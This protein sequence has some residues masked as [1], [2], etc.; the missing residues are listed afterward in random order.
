[1]NDQLSKRLDYVLEKYHEILLRTVSI[2]VTMI[3]FNFQKRT[4]T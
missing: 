2:L 4:T 1:M 3:G